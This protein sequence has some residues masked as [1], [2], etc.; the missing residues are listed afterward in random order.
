[1]GTPSSKSASGRTA[2][3]W[4]VEPYPAGSGPGA[5]PK[6][7]QAQ[8]RDLT[9]R[10]YDGILRAARTW[11]R[12]PVLSHAIEGVVPDTQYRAAL[13][14]ALRDHEGGRYS[15][16]LHPDLYNTLLARLA[17]ESENETLLTVREASG[18]S[19]YAPVTG[20][21]PTM[22][23]SAEIRKFATTIADT[24]PGVAFDLATLAFKLAEEEQDEGQGQ[25][26]QKQAGEIPEAF[27]EHMKKKD[28]D[29]GQ[30]EGQKQ[31]SYRTLKAAVIRAAQANPNAR[32]TF[33]PLLQTIKKLG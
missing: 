27:K 11:M 12:S 23:A 31:A 28:D 30:D 7:E 24:N 6:W 3:Y 15:V 20:E 32:A 19:L 21:E 16:G 4:G 18:G 1:M 2:V 17:G 22:R 26:E 13:D 25:A 33:L 29:K 8:A 9:E 10:D 5:Y 14:L